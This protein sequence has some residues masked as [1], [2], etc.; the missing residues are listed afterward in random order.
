M[1]QRLLLIWAI[2]GL[3]ILLFFCACQH[4]GPRIQ[5]D[6][7]ARG[8]ALLDGL[9]TSRTDAV[10]LSVDGRDV[11]LHGTVGD[12]ATRIRLI[13]AMRGLR[14]VRMVDDG[15]VVLSPGAGTAP[16][17]PENTAAGATARSAAAARTGTTP[18]VA[19]ATDP[20]SPRFVIGAAGGKLALR[21]TVADEASRAAWM[22]AARAR[23]GDDRVVDEL[24][25]GTAGALATMD[26]TAWLGALAL[27]PGDAGVDVADGTVEVHGSVPD[28]ANAQRFLD[29]VGRVSPQGWR[30]VD[31]LERVGA[32]DAATVQADLQEALSLRII[33]FATNSAELTVAGRQIVVRAAQALRRA[34]GLAV[35]VEGH[36]DSHG[37]EAWNV[38]LSRSRAETVA[39][40]LA[41]LGIDATRL[42]TAGYGSQRPIADNDTPHG[43]RANR[44]IEFHVRGG[45]DP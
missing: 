45:S 17:T 5:A 37:D 24:E 3:A 33:E 14:G 16:P 21:G 12:D 27:G 10:S 41:V 43:R 29:A 42:S 25:L 32:A 23:F 22:A 2:L 11:R 34:P 35:A 1:S 44:R 15:L 8:H 19:E 6:L 38:T 36:T 30:I 31:R 13:E 40:E 7:D 28:D 4:G 20:A 26:P 9:E 39:R 18:S